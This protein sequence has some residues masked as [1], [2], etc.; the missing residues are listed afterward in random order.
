MCAKNDTQIRDG[1]VQDFSTFSPLTARGL[2]TFILFQIGLP[3]A[4][5]TIGSLVYFVS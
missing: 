4:Y 1:T 2:T 3:M 5:E